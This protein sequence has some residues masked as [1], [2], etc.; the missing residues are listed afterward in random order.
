MELNWIYNGLGSIIEN[1][2]NIADF[3]NEFITSRKDI[4]HWY[5][6]SEDYQL[7][8]SRDS[9]GLVKGLIAGGLGYRFAITKVS[10]NNPEQGGTMTINSTWI[11]QNYG[12]F[13]ANAPIEWFITD[14]N[15]ND[16]LNGIDLGFAMNQKGNY[17]R[18]DNLY[19]M[20]YI[21]SIPNNIPAGTYDVRVA[22]VNTTTKKI[23]YIRL[24][25]KGMDMQGRYQLG[26]IQISKSSVM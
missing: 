24:A 4:A 16:Y 19:D 8:K 3:L 5:A 6:I 14:K 15:G 20:S 26:T 10:W 9:V 13:N 11:N 21:L 7:L 25:I 1:K 2:R 17:W 23:P 22:M 12:K 18:K